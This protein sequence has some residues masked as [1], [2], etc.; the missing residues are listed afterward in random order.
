MIIRF[1]LNYKIDIYIKFDRN[2]FVFYIIIYRKYTKILE[3][4]L[5]IEI[6]I[7]LE[8]VIRIDD[9]ILLIATNRVKHDLVIRIFLE[10]KIDCNTYIVNNF[11]VFFY[12]AINLF[13]TIETFFKYRIDINDRE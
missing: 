3:L 10:I 4:L 6:Y 11:N 13:S 9:F 1:L 12:Y 7:F 8:N 5:K 2:E